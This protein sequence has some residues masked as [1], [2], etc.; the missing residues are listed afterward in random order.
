M[1]AFSVAER[2]A[3]MFPPVSG[4][5]TG[6][7]SAEWQCTVDSLHGVEGA[8]TTLTEADSC[9]SHARAG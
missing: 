6:K 8:L 3:L 1:V 5:S 2:G 7:T 9:T 4:A